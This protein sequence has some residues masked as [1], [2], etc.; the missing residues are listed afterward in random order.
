MSNYLYKSF[1]EL[2]K[3][4]RTEDLWLMVF[5][6]LIVVLTI[7]ISIKI[8]NDYIKLIMFLV[9]QGSHHFQIDVIL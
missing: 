7:V 3:R 6:Y 1:I 8:E 4:A 2:I 5:F 9:T